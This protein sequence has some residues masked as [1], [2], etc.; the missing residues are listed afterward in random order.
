MLVGVCPRWVGSG[1][2]MGFTHGAKMMTPQKVLKTDGTVKSF[3]C[4]AAQIFRN[5]AY[6]EVRRSDKR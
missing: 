2:V 4:K 6:I 3:R 5:E 1:H